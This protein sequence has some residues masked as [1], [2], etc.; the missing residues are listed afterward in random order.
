M[1]ETRGD[2]WRWYYA[3]G[4]DPEVWYQADENSRAAAVAQG[5]RYAREGRAYSICQGR[6]MPLGDN[7]FKGHN[8]WE[9]FTEYNQDVADEDGRLRGEPTS[10]MLAVL[11]DRMAEAFGAW[12]AEFGVGRAWALETKDQEVILPTPWA[13]RRQHV[14]QWIAAKRFRIRWHPTVQR[15][16]RWW[17]ECRAS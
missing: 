15:M 8:L 7:F 5:S 2:I 10:T 13:V 1:S 14:S 16:R 9:E 3:D 17:R 12:R 11:E 6:A 4:V